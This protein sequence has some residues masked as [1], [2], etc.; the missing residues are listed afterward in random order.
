[1]RDK[2]IVRINY[3]FVISLNISDALTCF[4]PNTFIIIIIIIIYNKYC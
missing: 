4:K 3:L 2:D 1:M